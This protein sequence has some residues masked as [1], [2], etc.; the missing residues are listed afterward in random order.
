MCLPDEVQPTGK[1]QEGARGGQHW[2]PNPWPR[3][4]P[5]SVASSPAPARPGTRPRPPLQRPASAERHVLH[6]CAHAGAA[7]AGALG[8]GPAG[9]R[10]LGLRAGQRSG[11]AM[12]TPRSSGAPSAAP[13]G[14]LAGIAAPLLAGAGTPPHPS[15]PHLR[16]RRR[17]CPLLLL[18][19]GRRCRCRGPCH[20]RGP[21]R[22]RGRC[23]VPRPGQLLGWRGRRICAEVAVLKRFCCRDAP[24]GIKGHH[25]RQQVQRVIAACAKEGSSCRGRSTTAG[26]QA[27]MPAGS[28]IGVAACT[29]Q[30]VGG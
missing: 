10:H 29:Q 5:C 28:A 12:P 21:C 18:G 7:L 20:R 8:A 27:G 3:G 25:A 13:E 24:R 1:A 11:V 14:G 15:E 23:H 26:Q 16:R 2:P 22:R 9:R 30:R 6:H 19:A 17:L 4:P